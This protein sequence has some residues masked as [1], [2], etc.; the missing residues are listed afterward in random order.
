MDKEEPKTPTPC[1][2]SAKQ[3]Q[4]IIQ[5]N[6]VP[7]QD[8]ESDDD[9]M[10]DMLDE[11]MLLLLMKNCGDDDDPKND[12]RA[13]DFYTTLHDNLNK[14]YPEI[15]EDALSPDDPIHQVVLEILGTRSTVSSVIKRAFERTYK[16]PR[17]DLPPKQPERHEPIP[18]PVVDDTPPQTPTLDLAS[19]IHNGLSSVDESFFSIDTHTPITL[20]ELLYI[21]I[22]FHFNTHPDTAILENEA[23]Q[24]A[25]D[26][27]LTTS[28][29]PEQIR[30]SDVLAMHHY[31]T[32]D[33]ILQKNL[34]FG[35]HWTSTNI[36]ASLLH[37]EDK[38]EAKNLYDALQKPSLD[39]TLIGFNIKCVR[40]EKYQFKGLY[41]LKELD[42]AEEQVPIR[43]YLIVQRN[44]ESI[45]KRYKISTTDDIQT[46]TQVFTWGCKVSASIDPTF[47]AHVRNF[48]KDMAEQHQLLK[49]LKHLFDVMKQT[50]NDIQLLKELKTEDN[51]VAAVARFVMVE[52]FSRTR[53]RTFFL[54]AAYHHRESYTYLTNLY[55]AFKTS[56]MALKG[57]EEVKRIARMLMPV[58]S[59]NEPTLLHV[60]LKDLEIDGIKIEP[61]KMQDVIESYTGSS[62]RIDTM[63][64]SQS[65]PVLTSEITEW[66]KKAMKESVSNEDRPKGYD[67][68][69]SPVKLSTTYVPSLMTSYLESTPVA[70]DESEHALEEQKRD[71]ADY[72]RFSTLFR[73]LFRS[74]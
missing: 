48:L 7:P 23:T 60:L 32:P 46:L 26:V 59:Y 69:V 3:L 42:L 5:E 73:M 6:V 54:Q 64:Q 55:V 52:L 56:K 2:R 47:H 66:T 70:D 21:L 1:A 35:L 74:T 71:L 13:I 43:D 30:E 31:L 65:R 25:F 58:Q 17:L 53:L 15:F 33:L 12:D 19:R 39:P 29:P 49:D 62:Q 27:R 67:A 41:S 9:I 44:R 8:D 16:P 28:E 51:V 34:V 38:T 18:V 63:K 22:A 50:D 20:K 4:R 36:D 61:C 68:Y 40:K 45:L 11:D 14:T 24:P 72:K 37:E 10:D 57:I